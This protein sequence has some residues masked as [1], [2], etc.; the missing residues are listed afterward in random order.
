MGGFLGIGGSAS[1]RDRAEQIRSFEELHNVFNF[2]LPATKAAWGAG[3][4]GLQQAGAYWQKLLSGN[5]PAMLQA[6]EPEASAVRAQ[7]D[8]QKRQ[9]AASGTARGGGVAAANQQR[10]TNT[11]AEIDRMLFGVRPMAARE[12]ERIG[13][14]EL[15]AALQALGIG[16]TSAA[17]LGT[18]AL[19]SRK[20]SYEIN[21]D[22][23]AK[24]S[25]AILNVLSSIF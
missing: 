15:N 17:D 8:A 3:Q 7:S 9:L 19:K 16:E 25:T 24:A 23:V 14:T 5:R 13:S 11:M 1:K 2:A 10:E 12:T 6:V 20:Q 18:L 21:Q 22:M 4:E